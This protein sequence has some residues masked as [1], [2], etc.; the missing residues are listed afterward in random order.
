MFD[1]VIL[2]DHRYVNPT[3]TNWYIDQVLLEDKL[4]QSALEENVLKVS[5]ITS[6]T[7]IHLF[8]QD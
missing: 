5:D 8:M 7:F 3:T 6:Q 2:T 4:L 1:I